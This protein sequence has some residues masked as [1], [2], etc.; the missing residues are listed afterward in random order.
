M[1]KII[2]A[3]II[4]NKLGFLACF[5][6]MGFLGNT[7]EA[8]IS[9]ISC[10][11][12]QMSLEESNDERDQC[13]SCKRSEEIWS[14]SFTQTNSLQEIPLS[15][16]LLPQAFLENVYVQVLTFIHLE[17]MNPPPDIDSVWQASLIIKNTTVFVI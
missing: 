8:Q 3:V 16:L 7:V 5:S 12:S 11:E 1:K 17:R 4:F 10:H 13:Q 15:T 6:L 14:Q 2:S 9:N